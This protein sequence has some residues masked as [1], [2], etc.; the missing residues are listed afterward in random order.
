MTL[1]RL[2]IDTTNEGW[3]NINPSDISSW[4]NQLVD[5]LE[6]EIEKINQAANTGDSTASFSI[7]NETITKTLNVSTANTATIANVLATLIKALR[8]KGALA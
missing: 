1:P 5:E 4:A 2:V 6:N 7:S 3:A 8:D